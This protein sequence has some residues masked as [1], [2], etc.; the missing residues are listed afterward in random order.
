MSSRSKKSESQIKTKEAKH[1]FF[2]N[3]YV[4]MAF[5]RCPNCEEKKLENIV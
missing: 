4:D 5:T 1:Y 2:L 3:P